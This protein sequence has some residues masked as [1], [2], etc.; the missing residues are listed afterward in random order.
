VLETLRAGWRRYRQLAVT[1]IAC[2]AESAG[3]LA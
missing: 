2:P 1:R 3:E